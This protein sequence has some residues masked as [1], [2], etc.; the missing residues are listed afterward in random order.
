MESFKDIISGDQL[1]L[2]DFYATWCGPCKAMTPIISSIASE[3]KGKIRVLKID[4]D[5]NQSVAA[6]YNVQAV[7]TFII[8]RKGEI[9]WRKAGAMDKATLSQQINHLLNT[10][11]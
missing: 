2:V 3:M 5:K 7:P 1:V 9:V 10:N 6:H 11:N 8:F 4:I